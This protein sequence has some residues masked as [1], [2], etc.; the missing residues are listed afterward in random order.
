MISINLLPGGRRKKAGLPLWRLLLLLCLVAALGT[1]VFVFV[2]SGS[3]ASSIAP[4]VIAPPET[5]Q[6]RETPARTESAAQTAAPEPG[7]VKDAPEAV[8]EPRAL[9]PYS[10]A[11]VA[12]VAPSVPVTPVMPAAPVVPAVPAAP[13]S[14]VVPVAPAP[15]PEEREAALRLKT[16]KETAAEF[17]ALSLRVQGVSWSPAD[18][19]AMING[20]MLSA[21]EVVPGVRKEGDLRVEMIEERGVVFRYKGMRFRLPVEIFSRLSGEQRRE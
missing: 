14:P 18:A 12:P 17:A 13:V 5:R 1:G 3:I 19:R 4:P 11:P 20:R 16:R 15:G 8:E 2:R 9:Q 10:P 6:E 7:A 21:G